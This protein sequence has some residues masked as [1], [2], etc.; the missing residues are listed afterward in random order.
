MRN[1]ILGIIAGMALVYLFTLHDEQYN[2]LY[3]DMTATALLRRF[4]EMY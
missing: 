4:F 1:F 2:K 3:T